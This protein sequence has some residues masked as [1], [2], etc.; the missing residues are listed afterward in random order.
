MKIRHL[1]L[2]LSFFI[3]NKNALGQNDRRPQNKPFFDDKKWHF[4]FTLGPELQNFRVSNNSQDVIG[5]ANFTP[6]AA[7][8]GT[9]DGAFYYTEM[10]ERI[11]G[12]FHVGII[13]SRRLGEYFNLRMLPSLSL[14][15]RNLVSKL[16]TKE[17]LPGGETVMFSDEKFNIKTSIKTT[18]ISLPVLIKYK[19]ER[20][21]NF[22]PY[23]LAGGNIKY[24]LSRDLEDPIT[25]KRMDAY[26]EMGL[27]ADFYLPT[28]RFGL[29][30]R[31]SIGLLDI[32]EHERP[33]LDEM[34]YLTYSISKITSNVISIA[35]NFE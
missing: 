2:Y 18:H 7:T 27:G 3:L 5:Q 34:P 28:F 31:F 19:A 30:V 12:S 8:A 23:L 22:R 20:M 21:T 1:L 11:I 26:L 25:L 6:P 10:P 14:G 4:G 17:M 24:D 16:Y 13:T 32:L 35:F 15:Q 33:P 29:E 9:L